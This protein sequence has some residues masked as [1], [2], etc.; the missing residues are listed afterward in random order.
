MALNLKTYRQILELA[1]IGYDLKLKEWQDSYYEYSRAKKN[2][3]TTMEELKR[4]DEIQKEKQ[5]LHWSYA[6]AVRKFEKEEDILV[7]F[8]NCF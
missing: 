7:C 4:L 6:D 2:P 5:K 8:R 1:K 3:E